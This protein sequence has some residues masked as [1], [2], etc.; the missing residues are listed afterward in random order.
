MKDQRE[1][2]EI[3]EWYESGLDR[4]SG[5]K[6]T[7]TKIA[8]K[9]SKVFSCKPGTN[10]KLGMKKIFARTRLERLFVFRDDRPP[11]FSCPTCTKRFVFSYELER[12]MAKGKMP[13]CPGKHYCPFL[14]D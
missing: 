12:H 5:P 2:E 3:V 14:D 1:L 9:S 6:A 8:R 4:T 7:A 10:S 11:P 13:G